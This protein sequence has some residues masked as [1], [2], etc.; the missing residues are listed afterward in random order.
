MAANDLLVGRARI[1]YSGI[2][3]DINA[4]NKALSGIGSGKLTSWNTSIQKVVSDLN[5]MAKA[6]DVAAKAIGKIGASF[7]GGGSGGSNSGDI[8]A[9]VRSASQSVK[10]LGDDLKRVNDLY[11]TMAQAQKDALTALKSGDAGAFSRFEGIAKSYKESIDAYQRIVD[12]TGRGTQDLTTAFSRAGTS[13]KQ[14]ASEV[15]KINSQAVLREQKGQLDG[16]TKAYK[17]LEDAA[18]NF[19][20][21]EKAG[22]E[23]GKSYWRERAEAATAAVEKERI[24]IDM[25]RLTVEQRQK[26]LDILEKSRAAQETFKEGTE[27]ETSMVDNLSQQWDKVR[28]GIMMIAGI[29]LAKVWKDAVDYAK[30]FDAAVT[31]IAIITKQPLDNVRQMSSIYRTM[32]SD[33][34][35]TSTEIA[36]AAA[37][38]YRQGI[39]DPGVVNGVVSGATKFGAVTG[40]TT[41]EAIASMTAAMQN[42]KQESESTA[43]TVQRIGDTW[44]YMGDAVATN[45]EEI[46]NAM[47]KASASVKTVGVE[48]Q[49]ASSWAA[50]MLARTQQSGEV[51]GT[52]LNSLATRYMKITSKGYKNITEDDNGEALSFNDVSKALLEADIQMFDSATGQFR[53]MDSVLDELSGKW[54]GLDEATRRYIATQMAGT[55]GM[56]YFLT[57]MENY[58]D[59]TDLATASVEGQMDTKYDIWLQGVEAAQNNLKNSAEELYAVLSAN[60]LAGAYNTIAGI[61]DVFTAGTTALDGWNLKLPAIIA[62]IAGL[63]VGVAKLITTVRGFIAAGGISGIVNGLAAG[64]L[65]ITAI[66]VALGALATLVGVIISAVK[67]DPIDLTELNQQLDEINS[68]A[69]GLSNIKDELEAI[70]G[71]RGDQVSMQEFVDLRKQ[72]VEGSPSLQA[73]YGKEGEAIG[74]VSDALAIVNSELDAYNRKRQAL[75]TSAHSEY[76]DQLAEDL[77][78]Y[79]ASSSDT[80]RY[81]P[82]SRFRAELRHIGVDEKWMSDDQILERVMTTNSATM[83]RYL[84]AVRD[85][86]SDIPVDILNTIKD[87]LGSAYNEM[88]KDPEWLNIWGG[89]FDEALNAV[90]A[91]LTL[92]EDDWK[93]IGQDFYDTVRSSFKPDTGV[94]L[95]GEGD[96]FMDDVIN[97]M[98]GQM[99]AD[100]LYKPDDPAMQELAKDIGNE[101]AKILTEGVSQETLDALSSINNSQMIF[102]G[103]DKNPLDDFIIGMQ[104]SINN[105][106]SAGIKA[107]EATRGRS[108]TDLADAWKKYIAGGVSTAVLD[109]FNDA[110]D[111]IRSDTSLSM[112]EQNAK[113]RELMT[114]LLNPE[115]GNDVEVIYSMVPEIEGAD[116]SDLEE[117]ATDAESEVEKMADTINSRAQQ[118]AD[119]LNKELENLFNLG[120]AGTGEA[121]GVAAARDYWQQLADATSEGGEKAEKEVKEAVSNYQTAV[122][123]IG[124][125]ENGGSIKDVQNNLASLGLLSI[126]TDADTAMS[127]L[128]GVRQLLEE[129]YGADFLG[130]FVEPAVEEANKILGV[131][132]QNKEARSQR[133]A[134]QNAIDQYGTDKFYDA[135]ASALGDLYVDG[136]SAVQMFALLNHKVEESNDIWSNYEKKLGIVVEETEE[137]ASS[138]QELATAESAYDTLKEA[139]SLFDSDGNFIGTAQEYV[140]LVESLSEFGIEL[141]PNSTVNAFTTIQQA[142]ATTR[143]KGE[144]LAAVLGLVFGGKPGAPDAVGLGIDQRSN[145]DALAGYEERF[146]TL[147]KYI[148]IFKENSGFTAQQL[149]ELIELFP[150]LNLEGM[151]SSEVFAVLSGDMDRVSF[152]GER[153][154]KV[155]GTIWN[156][157]DKDAGL[158]SLITPESERYEKA[159]G[160]KSGM[161]QAIGMY[162]AETGTFNEGFFFAARKALGDMYEEGM[163]NNDMLAL[164]QNQVTLTNIAWAEYEERI[165]IASEKT[166]EAAEAQKSFAE[167]MDEIIQKETDA[168]YAAESLADVYNILAAGGTIDTDTLLHLAEKFP[169]YAEFFKSLGEGGLSFIPDDF[170]DSAMLEG[171]SEVQKATE[172]LAMLEDGQLTFDEYENLVG[173]FSELEGMDVDQMMEYLNSIISDQNDKWK[174]I[175]ETLGI[176]I[177]EYDLLSQETTELNSPLSDEEKAL[178]K[179]TKAQNTNYNT[180]RLTAKE[181]SSLKKQYPDLRK[182]IEN[183]ASGVD[184]GR[185]LTAALAKEINK[186]NTKNLTKNLD[187]ALTKLEDATE[188]TEDYKDAVASLSDVFDFDGFG[189]LDNLGFV[190]QNL[191]DIQAAAAGSEEA[192]RRLQEA[193]YINVVGTSSVDFSAVQNG[194][195]LVGS[196]AEQV[197]A[198]LAQMGM[199][200]IETQQVNQMMP[201]ARYG[202]DG[203]LSVAMEQFSGYVQVWKPST[204]N[205]FAG[206]GSVGGG[207]GR[208]SSGGGGGGGGGRGG[209]GGGGG[210]SMSVS[211]AT[212]SLIDNIEHQQDNFDNRRKLIDLKKEYHEL[213][214]EIQGEIVYTQ[215]EAD[216]I[217]EQSTA[218]QDNIKTLEAEIKKQEQAIA[219]NSQSSQA[220]KQAELD[221]A[222]LNKAHREYS[223]KLLENTNRL[224]KIKK[225]LDEFNE[226]ARQTV[227]SVQE[228]IR[229]TIEGRE[230]HLRDMLDGTVEVEDMILEVIKARYERERDLAIETAKAKQNAIDEEIDAIDRLINERKKLLDSQKEE[231]EIAD[232]QA[233]IKRISADPTRRKE[234]LELQAQL[235]EKQ[236]E[237][238]W[239]Q[240]EEDL[241]AQKEALEQE[242]DNLD[243]YISDVEEY[244]EE[245]FKH[246]DKL[247]AEM[248]EVIKMSDAEII[249]WLKANVEEFDSY[250]AK[251][252][253]QTV[254]AWQESLNQMRGYTET[255]QDEIEEIMSW[256]NEEILEWLKQNNVDFANASKEQQESFL[257]EWKNTL[258]DWRN[259]YKAIVAEINSYDYKV[260]NVGTYSYGGGGGGGGYGGG[261]GGYGGYSGGTTGY[262]GSNVNMSRSS[263]HQVTQTYR[264]KATGSYAAPNGKVYTREVNS[265]SN[266]SAAAAGTDARNKLLKLLND[267]VKNAYKS[268]LSAAGL[269]SSQKTLYTKNIADP[270]R[271]I[272]NV[273]VQAYARG[274]LNTSTGLAWLDG[275]PQRPERVLSAYQTELFE[276]LLN[277]LHVIRVS[278]LSGLNAPEMAGS[279]AGGLTI[280]TINVNV[281]N[282]DTDDD[283]E[284]LADRIGEVMN[285]RLRQTMSIGGVNFV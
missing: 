231:K 184:D 269:T 78:N 258:D 89:L 139:V 250:T 189:A 233:K 100:G 98:F 36:R 278:G 156:A 53:E 81:D 167:Q 216:V 172:A 60:T 146:D 238:S 83:E 187:A 97:S 246:P 185:E 105:M 158:A 57:L 267:E 94:K 155:L 80:A 106:L 130:Q 161:E 101:Y 202:P 71:E 32:A 259:A 200:Y 133:E 241:N 127:A 201:V 227:I 197:G 45:G 87:V 76:K 116:E 206:R 173:M 171:L 4:I 63:A 266:V 263:M 20:K 88:G 219:A 162:N 279:S 268:A 142:M 159:M 247:I 56:N 248:Q 55:R 68:K 242:R 69:E 285:R 92:K 84:K 274:G 126:A 270:S 236:E 42:F 104:E 29:S 134:W 191:A 215:M 188:G 14:F 22:D 243:D 50:I 281:D 30:E 72:I 260:P 33:L 9:A 214:G 16:I 12:I 194:M 34:G 283:Y 85:N 135:A 6:A 277:T 229:D 244:Y 220:Y 37:T 208:K 262:S 131:Y 28:R 13:A 15:A 264:M 192:F 115:T 218:L 49:T 198:L 108:A 10:S 64:Q 160:I 91:Q 150:E 209:G 223:E 51:I 41:D 257:F 73:A 177:D 11:K 111:Y 117:A 140:K 178:Q 271:V 121:R 3:A 148:D 230:E 120:F 249:E 24:T 112:D 48:F 90:D 1:D 124:I 119:E 272:R 31:D 204:G 240:Y 96:T 35:V 217:R 141:D 39:S 157:D 165:G 254:A 280:E 147:S 193:A 154:A 164:M 152:A 7:S 145:L 138:M 114:Q 199:G 19:R 163:T 62:G 110:V 74:T 252:Q 61:V 151:S 251:K 232:L 99:T 118:K 273:Q 67:K 180:Q 166:E 77:G 47:S 245:L 275:T 196:Q 176:V 149:Q 86:A 203:S 52:Q 221:L 153:L 103:M 168:K 179:L 195:A 234:L 276:D 169:E 27:E 40:M 66:L 213:R 225:E 59:A 95:F 253:E 186:T 107:A 5:S 38:I 190:Q 212:K 54:D 284:T 144:E 18:R 75:I 82:Y 17:S 183:Y 170:K 25:S 143:K 136:M 23:A 70:K 237:K 125:L 44:S 21:A 239:N 128:D 129:I 235:A 113:I 282:L 8:G 174:E 181:L 261:G 46:A 123:A 79:R 211:D 132:E 226:K 207:S 175:A 26:I 65:H 2:Q 205:P 102:Q 137:V 222:E 255:Y 122:E 43:D 256:T 224:E 58:K 93:Q 109:G 210:G 228:L 182:E 265:T